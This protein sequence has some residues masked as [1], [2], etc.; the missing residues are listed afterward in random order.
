[1]SKQEHGLITY[2]DPLT[3]NKTFEVPTTQ[4]VHCGLPFPLPRPYQDKSPMAIASRK[5]RAFCVKCMG[6]VCGAGCAD[7]VPWEAMLEIEEGIRKK[8]AVSTAVPASK[9]WLPGQ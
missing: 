8:T 6:H 5:G 2:I 7:C 9:L 3:G 4:C 1:M